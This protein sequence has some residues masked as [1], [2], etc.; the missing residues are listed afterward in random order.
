M[1]TEV[2]VTTLHDE[3]ANWNRE[4]DA[5]GTIDSSEVKDRQRFLQDQIHQTYAYTSYLELQ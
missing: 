2:S 1:D 4:L 5:T 3:V